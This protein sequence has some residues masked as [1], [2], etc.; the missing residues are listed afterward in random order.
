M[1]KKIRKA[2][3]ISSVYELIVFILVIEDTYYFSDFLVGMVLWSIPTIAYWA[4]I[5][6]R[7]GD[8][9]K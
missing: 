2:I 7:A 1:T 9:P 3:V 6:I 5:F 4:W 8:S